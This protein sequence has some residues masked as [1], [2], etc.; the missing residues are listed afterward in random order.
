MTNAVAMNKTSN[1]VMPKHYVELDKDEM[2]YVEGGGL[3]SNI[4]KWAGAIIAGVGLAVALVGVIVSFTPAAPIGH[5]MVAWGLL[6][7]MGG[8]YI[9]A[10]GGLI[11]IKDVDFP[12][13]P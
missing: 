3:F 7:Y 9:L 5:A 1:L 10:M 6:G 12:E 4:C 2:S 11:D 13:L 8:M